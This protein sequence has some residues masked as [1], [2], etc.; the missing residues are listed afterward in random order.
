[1][2][3]GWETTPEEMR[4]GL[5]ETGC[6][7]ANWPCEGEGVGGTAG[8]G[9]REAEGV[10]FWSGCG[11]VEMIST[12]KSEQEMG[13][14]PCSA[15]PVPGVVSWLRTITV[16]KSSREHGLRPQPDRNCTY[17]SERAFASAGRPEL[18]AFCSSPRIGADRPLTGAPSCPS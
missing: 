16:L 15:S 17:G 11:R 2:S 13:F 6:E 12:H 3:S 1:M 9:G 8:G 4:A 5:G 10:S 7:R 18:Q 14:L